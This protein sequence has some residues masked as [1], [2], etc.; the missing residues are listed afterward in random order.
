MVD[1]SPAAP[2]HPHAPAAP[3]PSVRDRL[4][5]DPAYQAFWILRVGFT[6]APILF[7]LDKF[8]NWM[9]DW[10]AYFAPWVA[11]RTPGSASQFMH[12]VGVIEIAAGLL[13]A[14]RPRIGGY[15][16]AAWLFGIIAN[17]VIQLTFWDIALRDFGLA[18]GAI[19][20]ARLATAYERTGAASGQTRP[21]RT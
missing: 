1:V 19:A 15:V 2:T 3:R 10:E 11:D 16:V 4:V 17:L 21:D 18:L 12:V 14:I 20:L 9:V 7:G 8:L 13:V 5:T 6:V